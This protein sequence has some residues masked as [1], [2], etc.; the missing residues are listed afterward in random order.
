MARPVFHDQEFCRQ[1]E[2]RMADKIFMLLVQEPGY[3]QCTVQELR[4]AATQAAHKITD[5]VEVK[6]RGV[7]E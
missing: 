2:T 5:D 3:G 6:R 1:V 7:A 4:E